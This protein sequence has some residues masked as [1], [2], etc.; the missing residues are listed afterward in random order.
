MI[1]EDAEIEHFLNTSQSEHRLKLLA[2]FREKNQ[3]IPLDLVRDLMH[4]KMSSIELISLLENCDTS[5]RLNLENFITRGLFGWDQNV[6]S[7]AIRFWASETDC[8]LWHR[9]HSLSYDAQ[10][11]QRVSYTLLDVA[12]HSSGSQLIQRFCDMK[13]LEDMSPAFV[14]LLFHRALIWNLENPRLLQMG[15]DALKTSSDLN[16]RAD[17][18]I[19]HIVAYFMKFNPS[20]LIDG[21]WTE[22][23]GGVWNDIIQSLQKQIIDQNSIAGLKRLMKKAR[24]DSKHLMDFYFNWPAMWNRQFLDTEVI[25][26][27]LSLLSHHGIER[28]PNGRHAHEIFGGM[29]SKTLT[30]SVMNLS[31]SQ[32]FCHAIGILGNL[33]DP[34]DSEQL[35]NELKD[36]VGAAKDPTQLI[37]KIPQK[38]RSRI[39]EDNPGIFSAIAEERAKVMEDPGSEQIL[40]KFLVPETISEDPTERSRFQF[41]RVAFHGDRTVPEGQGNFWDRLAKAWLEPKEESLD[42]LAKDARKIDSVYQIFYIETLSR[43]Q[44]IDKAAL[45]LLDYVRSSEEDVVGAVIRA[46]AGIG[47]QRALQ[48][49]VAFLTRP[50]ITFNLQMDISQ[51]LGERDVAGLQSELRSAIDDLYVDPNSEDLQ[52]ELKATLRDLLQVVPAKENEIE[53]SAQGASMP[54]STELDEMLVGKIKSYHKLSSEVKRAL[55]TAQFFHLQVQTAGNLKTIDLSPTI[56]MQYKALE[57]S[58]RENFEG[59]CGVL[60]NQG[61]L[62]R[63][64]DVIGYARPIPPAM[65]EFETFIE[66]LPTIKSIPF[67]SRFKL[68]KMLRA[69]CQF[70]KG[71]RFT[72]DGLKAFGL[73][74]ACFSRQECKYGLE[75]LFPVEGLTDPELYDF[76]KSLHIF[77]DFRNRAA[78]EGFHPDA[79]NDLDGI[80]TDTARIIEMM[81]R[82]SENL[83][84]ANARYHAGK[85]SKGAV[86]VH[87]NAS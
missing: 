74:F 53:P 3:K 8:L 37:S 21:S 87:K 25:C 13:G 51:I 66:N 12:W 72:L 28:L 27:A 39:Q 20:G 26:D 9:T 16:F 19:P 83:N 22:R 29:L 63:K 41:M 55:R 11:P 43:F 40:Q 50:N 57:L 4:A 1:L 17:K 68:R 2:S 15:S 44:G 60:I 31:D 86:I 34:T 33:I 5:N 47:T 84:L 42:N 49:I 65:E 18:C 46:L 69:L 6:A 78:H 73:F 75:K 45:K 54:T 62:Q 80:W 14:A 30:E 61:V 82:F 24:K 77:Q 58:F 35:L 52:W 59:P 56:D 70:R 38:L 48:E 23:V 79:S 32:E 64:L 36:K 76:V 81:F 67:F 71:K 7:R 10:L 85:A